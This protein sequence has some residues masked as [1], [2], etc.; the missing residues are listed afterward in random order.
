M[1]EWQVAISCKYIERIIKSTTSSTSSS[2]SWALEPFHLSFS[3]LTLQETPGIQ[4][5]LC[6]WRKEEGD[7]GWGTEGLLCRRGDNERGFTPFGLNKS[8]PPPPA[9]FTHTLLN[10]L[11]A[12]GRGGAECWT[13]PFSVSGDA[14][15]SWALFFLFFGWGEE[16]YSH[17]PSPCFTDWI[18]LWY[19]KPLAWTRGDLPPCSGLD[20]PRVLLVDRNQFK[21]WPF[22]SVSSVLLQPLKPSPRTAVS[23]S[24]AILH[25]ITAWNISH[26]EMLDINITLPFKSVEIPFCNTVP[27][28]GLCWCGRHQSCRAA[29][30]LQGSFQRTQHNQSDKKTVWCDFKH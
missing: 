9:L 12:H 30:S 22:Q 23:V 28:Y 1:L 24:W 18:W 21:W 10:C 5:I 4:G 19:P 26:S 13:P 25:I 7:R 2:S 6:P 16:K 15:M 20:T 3:Y 17:L 29:Y 8:T 27:P 11:P 14:S